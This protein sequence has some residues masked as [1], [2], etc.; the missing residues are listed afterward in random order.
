M[1]IFDRIDPHALETRQRHLW[2]LTLTVLSIFAVG[3]ALLMFPAVFSNAVVLS[4]TISRKTFFVF[5]LLTVLLMSYLVERQFV[6]NRLTTKLAQEHRTMNRL[7]QEAST[8]LLSTLPDFEAFR[9]RLAMEQRR[10][11]AT[12]QPLSVVTVALTPSREF[13]DQ[14]EIGTAFGDAAKNLMHSLRDED[15]I[16][17][18]RQGVFCVL[19]PDVE[20]TIADKMAMRLEQGLRDAW[21]AGSRFSFEVATK[22]LNYP[23]HVTSA[24]EIEEAVL[25]LVH[26]VPAQAAATN[27]MA[28]KTD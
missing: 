7:R 26:K 28:L 2:L 24:R 12:R 3:M 22:V 19:L 8:D 18:F 10:A 6:I 25:A 13:T 23:E 9:D 17:Y 15:S 16:Y 14:I 1:Q 11:S 5:C 4:G 20:V 21:G 27:V